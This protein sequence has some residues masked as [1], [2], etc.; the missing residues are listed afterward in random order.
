MMNA[1]CSNSIPMPISRVRGAIASRKR[2]A[3][4]SGGSGASC[5]AVDTSI[6]A[7]R[8]A[9]ASLVALGVG[10][11]PEGG[12]LP[13][14]QQRAARRQRGIDPRVDRL[15]RHVDIDVDSIALW[16]WCIHLLEPDRRATPCRVDQLRI[17]LGFGFV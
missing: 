2:S 6:S 10:Q 3:K 8:C 1:N 7:L 4:V 12:C 14:G 11:H 17:Q 5:L 13:I 15:M 16:P 9:E